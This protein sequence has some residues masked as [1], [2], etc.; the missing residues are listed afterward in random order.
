MGPKLRYPGVI[1]TC[2]QRVLAINQKHYGSK[3]EAVAKQM[4]EVGLLLG[5]M[6]QSR[7]EEETLKNCYEMVRELSAAGR[8]LR[9]LQGNVAGTVGMMYL[10]RND[11]STSLQV[12]C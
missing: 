1:L 10:M 6:K 7:E 5:M 2:L 11:I 9:S 3:H 8:P 4:R 12:C